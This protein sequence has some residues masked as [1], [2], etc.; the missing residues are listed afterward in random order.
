[1]KLGFASK[2]SKETNLFYKNIVVE[3]LQREGWFSFLEEPRSLEDIANKFDYTDKDY[4]KEILD[5]L[6]SDDTI[7][8]KEDRYKTNGAIDIV[9]VK[10]QIF[11]ESIMDYSRGYAKSIPE[12][13]RGKYHLV[14]TGYNLFNM[15]DAL[16]LQMYKTMRRSAFAFGNVVNLKGKFLDIGC[17]NGI[18][19]ADIW[20]LYFENN[21][22]NHHKQIEIYGIDV[23][24]DM[25]KIAEEEFP[26]KIKNILSLSNE[27]I[28]QYEGK[29]PKLKEGTAIEI[30]FEDNYFDIVY[31]SQV[32]HWTD[33]RKAIKEMYRVVKPGGIVFG[34]SILRPMANEYLH[35]NMKTV[36]GAHGFFTK[37]EMKTWIK[38]A[39]FKEMSFSTPLTIFKLVK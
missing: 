1:M 23:N 14:T 9:D 18:G 32:L 25:L 35:V 21:Y 17:G 27:A 12:R 8:F 5:A 33:P 34:T 19:T 24:S 31:I 30:P 16:S 38:E 4:L 15:D 20:T 36:Q 37:K 22:F 11:N 2:L 7:T 39:G 26:L 3:V 10:P 29:F 13:L 6:L 28:K